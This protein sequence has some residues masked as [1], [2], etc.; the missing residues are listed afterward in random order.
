[1]TKKEVLLFLMGFVSCAILLYIIFYAGTE[2]ALG[3]GMASLETA[4]PSDWIKEDDITLFD[5]MIILRVKGATISNYASTGSMRPTIDEGANGIRI[6]P[7]KVE[8]IN[9][10][11]I[12]SF[13]LD[14]KMVVHR[15]VA[16]GEDDDGTYFV[17][18]GDNAT[19]SDGKIRFDDI[20][21]VTIGVLW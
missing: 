2:I 16:R 6:I 7:E 5:E 13:E 17:T 18:Q 10:G 15:I 12:V 3:T 4:S 8:D 20:K 1:M 21:Y 19:F 9:V 14:K 11:D